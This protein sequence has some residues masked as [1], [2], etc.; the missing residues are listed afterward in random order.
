MNARLV[1]G[2]TA[3]EEERAEEEKEEDFMSFE[4]VSDE[5]MKK[6]KIIQ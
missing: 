1:D 6:G 5:L 2:T 3:V 4:R